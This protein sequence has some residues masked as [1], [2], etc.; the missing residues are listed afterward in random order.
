MSSSTNMMSRMV[1]NDIIILLLSDGVNAAAKRKYLG[2]VP[3]PHSSSADG[4]RLR[5]EAA[6]FGTFFEPQ[7]LRMNEL[8]LLPDHIAERVAGSH[9]PCSF[10][11]P[12]TRPEARALGGRPSIVKVCE[13]E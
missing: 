3:R 1:P 5:V 12:T 2:I 6:E 11:D 9:L 4:I 10:A 7:R 13:R 8:R